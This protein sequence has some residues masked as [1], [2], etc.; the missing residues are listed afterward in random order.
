M[1]RSLC[2]FGNNQEGQLGTSTVSEA[3]CVPLEI[4]NIILDELAHMVLNRKQSVIVNKDGSVYN[5][6]DNDNNELGRSGKR[7][8]FRRIQLL[9]TDSIVDFSLGDNGWSIALAN[10]GG[11]YSWGVN[12]M[13]ELGNGTR[14]RVDKPKPN[15]KL[16][17]SCGG[18]CVHLVSGGRHS[19][20]ITRTVGVVSW[21]TNRKGQLGTDS[22]VL[23]QQYLSTSSNL[24]ATTNSVASS[25]ASPP[26]LEARSILS[27]RHR[28]VLSVACGEDFSL[29]LTTTGLLYS[30]GDN[31]KAQLGLGDLKVRYRPTLVTS[32]R[33]AKVTAI[34]AGGSHCG[35]INKSG[36]VLMWGSNSH[37]Q[38][39][40]SPRECTTVCVPKVV[41]RFALDHVALSLACGFAHTMQL[42]RHK[43][44]PAGTAWVYGMGLNRS[45]QL[46]LGHCNDVYIPAAVMYGTGSGSGSDVGVGG[47]TQGP[48][49]PL[50]EVSKATD[51]DDI[52]VGVGA[53]SPVAL[54]S[55]STSSWDRL[56]NFYNRLRSNAN[57]NDDDD[58]DGR[59]D[60]SEVETSMPPEV[61][62][63]V[64]NS[65]YERLPEPVAVAVF[66]GA[67]ANHSFVLF[68]KPA[69]AASVTAVAAVASSE[70]LQCSH[71]ALLTIAPSLMDALEKAQQCAANSPYVVPDQ[72]VARCKQ[73]V[74]TLC[75]SPSLLLIAFL[76]STS[77][78][79]ASGKASSG[80]S[81]NGFN[82]AF[83]YRFFNKI[84]NCKIP[85]C[86]TALIKASSQ[87]VDLLKFCPTDET[88]NVAIYCILL[89]NPLLVQV[90]KHYE[91]LE[92]TLVGLCSLPPAARSLLYTDWF[93]HYPVEYFSQ[94][95]ALLL[96]YLSYLF[97][98]CSTS[99][100]AAGSGQIRYCLNVLKRL[101]RC[102]VARA[103]IVEEA[104]YNSDVPKYYILNLEWLMYKQISA[105][106]RADSQQG[107]QVR[108]PG[109]SPTTFN[110]N[111]FQYS[112]LISIESKAS[113]LRFECQT[114]M[115]QAV[116]RQV[117]VYIKQLTVLAERAAAQIRLDAAL[118]RI[119]GHT[120]PGPTS[121]STSTSTDTDTTADTAL[122][123]GS[124]S[125]SS[126]S[127]NGNA[128][129]TI[130][131]L[132]ADTARMASP[133]SLGSG[134]DSAPFSS[135]A[136][137]SNTSAG[138]NPQS[139]PMAT[140]S[141]AP[142][143]EPDSI[144][145]PLQQGSQEPLLIEIPS[146]GNV[147]SR[148]RSLVS[149]SPA[150]RTDI[151][152][153]SRPPPLGNNGS[154][155]PS[156]SSGTATP[157]MANAHIQ[158]AAPS[159]SSMPRVFSRA[160]SLEELPTAD[161]IPFLMPTGVDVS[162]FASP[163]VAPNVVDRHATPGGATWPASTSPGARGGGPIFSSPAPAPATAPVPVLQPG[164]AASG[165]GS[166][167]IVAPAPTPAELPSRMPTSIPPGTMPNMVIEAV[168]QLKL[169][170]ASLFPEAVSQVTKC[171]L[172]DPA[173]LQLPLRVTF[174][175]EEAIDRG[176]VMKEFFALIVK[177]FIQASGLLAIC[178]S[179]VW[180]TCAPVGRNPDPSSPSFFLE[181]AMR[182][183]REAKKLPSK[184]LEL[185]A[186]ADE[187]GSGCG[188]ASSFAEFLLGV[189]VGMAF[190]NNVLIDL[191]LPSCIYKA[192]QRDDAMGVSDLCAVDS[193][194]SRSLE[195]LLD[196]EEE[197]SGGRIEDVFCLS[198]VAPR[199]PIL[200]SYYA[201][202]G[203]HLSELHR[204]K[205]ELYTAVSQSSFALEVSGSGGIYIEGRSS[206]SSN[207]SS[208]SGGAAPITGVCGKDEVLV[209][210]MDEG[211]ADATGDA[212]DIEAVGTE[213]M[214]V[215]GGDGAN[216]STSTSTCRDRFS[217]NKRAKLNDCCES[218]CSLSDQESAPHT[219]SP[220][221]VRKARTKSSGDGE[222]ET[223]TFS[224]S[225]SQHTQ[226]V[227]AHVS[228]R[229][230]YS[231]LL[232]GGG[233]HVS[234]RHEY[235]ELLPGGGAHVSH[236]HEYSELLP[237]GGDMEVTRANRQQFCDLFV[238]HTLFGCVEDQV[239][240]YML[241]IQMVLL[242]PHAPA[243]K[244]PAAFSAP[245]SRS[246]GGGSGLSSAAA[247]SGIPSANYPAST[248]TST[249][250]TEHSRDPPLL[251]ESLWVS[252]LC[253]PKEIDILLGGQKGA[254][255]NLITLRA[256][257]RY[258]GE[259][260]DKH[261]IIEWF[262][263]VIQEL[264]E[265]ESK[266]FL[267]FVT[268]SDRVNVGGLSSMQFNIQ[269]NG[270]SQEALPS[271]HTCFNL[272][273]LPTTY[274]SKA[275][276]RERLVLAL[277]HSYG[278]GFA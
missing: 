208:S 194:V 55:V 38:C 60:D 118:A 107:R 157:T 201:A 174:A 149:V 59:D 53:G 13:G 10:Q 112:F 82:V 15:G 11:L 206:S 242:P 12:S 269:S 32:L 5:C 197:E 209:S 176:G 58:D 263:E 265:E 89:A 88:E 162:S 102:N 152:P 75:S 253:S 109:G 62:T 73:Q 110:F 71:G 106:S 274:S 251:S 186:R 144:R 136:A 190:Y 151:L 270:M 229:H 132:V 187:R 225:S 50:V 221:R 158:A 140:V 185:M 7:S 155:E 230:E 31:S 19:V 258:H 211:D 17:G 21:G 47:D 240:A 128:S 266:K 199:N 134:S 115:Q 86:T 123:P 52:G 137:N 164:S 207:N 33:S 104:F 46:G 42:Y 236:R 54:E 69:V 4:S 119:A 126:S 272:L 239:T 105:D 91:L 191:P 224:S 68:D 30:W 34:S 124:S 103:I 226:P 139:T 80:S 227:P 8:Q 217:T 169:T 93:A 202:D 28:P 100:V 273:D 111:I 81:V 145:T 153:P 120:A 36:C 210:S 113:V 64:I 232:P 78:A 87:L 259:F 95:V 29:A 205:S 244:P 250:T 204:Q 24:T 57:S 235:S 172:D 44:D 252:H 129:R 67:L 156:S 14:E 220:E 241:G 35:C 234:H 216:A 161:V 260:N 275:S 90:S 77:N 196:Y 175:N 248:S 43:R 84:V 166:N 97:V 63:G 160:N 215:C 70:R 188:S 26:V 146:A 49:D 127:G 96:K 85:E 74:Y 179:I 121:T 150:M 170:R 39:G 231:E 195:A 249:S 131:S 94:L 130:A 135:P 165:R 262:W 141:V 56:R 101:Y 27:L 213:Q 212:V 163:A 256:S 147:Y 20:A 192:A 171:L 25:D 143:P 222:T 268:G 246:M 183:L 122:S 238:K 16:T 168:F 72:L 116:N 173:T 138:S 154:T 66:T 271:S 193:T 79:S 92:K 9:E 254:V 83:C 178:D 214:H 45:G 117:V 40:V 264:T 125:S 3:E 233:A 98:V 22:S 180:F 61:E 99:T 203:S 142:E 148:Q 167:P 278:F 219:A 255:D 184:L 114:M 181:S 228:H 247:S 133:S 1:S 189:F 18:S 218:N 41:E 48:Q 198:F 267:H 159:S 261:Q 223:V 237:G 2:A 6:G 177:E 108:S 23:Q 276:L 257:T 65:G 76:D 37:G 182:Q 243:S 277:Q 51:K 245:P 200:D